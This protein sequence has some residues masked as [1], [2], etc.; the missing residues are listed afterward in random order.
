[1]R[2]KI[3]GKQGNGEEK[4]KKRGKMKKEEREGGTGELVFNLPD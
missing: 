2:M 3:Q 4:A 1:M